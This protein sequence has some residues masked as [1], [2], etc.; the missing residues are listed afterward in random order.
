M[1]LG[2]VYNKLM[3]DVRVDKGLRQSKGEEI[4]EIIGLY[5]S[6]KLVNSNCIHERT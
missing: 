5:N 4:E 3:F 1:V 2:N 6:E